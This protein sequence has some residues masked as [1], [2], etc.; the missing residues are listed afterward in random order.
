MALDDGADIDPA[1][2]P[3]NLKLLQQ[4]DSLSN[5]APAP[6]AAPAQGDMREL[7][8]E[9]TREAAAALHEVLHTRKADHPLE[10]DLRTALAVAFARTD[11]AVLTEAKLRLDGWPANLGGFDLAVVGTDGS[12]VLL[13]TKWGNVWQGVWDILKLASG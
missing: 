4:L 1:T 3:E 13:E 11:A 9:A 6:L 2:L 8:I 5:A 7:V 10:E 12:L